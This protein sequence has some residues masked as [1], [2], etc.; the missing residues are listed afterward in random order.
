VNRIIIDPKS[1]P[2]WKSLLL[3]RQFVVGTT[4]DL[5]KMVPSRL[6][7]EAARFKIIDFLLLKKL[8]V[9]GDWFVDTKGTAIAGYMKGSPAD[10]NVSLSLAD[11]G[12]DVEEYKASLNGHLNEKRV[13]DGKTINGSLLYSGS[14]Q[15]RITEDEW[16]RNHVEINSNFLYIADELLQTTSSTRKSLPHLQR[17]KCFRS[18]CLLSLEVDRFRK[19]QK[20]KVCRTIE[21]KRKRVEELQSETAVICGGDMPNKRKPK[22]KIRHE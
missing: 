4:T 20:E 22:P 19:V 21:K 6:F 17:S 10:P 12:I 18:L 7:D 8:L 9:K 11:F 3:K 15:K 1:S 2:I 13:L 5:Y 16:L 14:L